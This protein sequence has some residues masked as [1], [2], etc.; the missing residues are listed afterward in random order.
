MSNY[1]LI[2]RDDADAFIAHS[3]G[4]WKKHKYI[5]K[6][7]KRYI[8]SAAPEFARKA[9]EYE[10]Y[11]RRKS[12]EDKEANNQTKRAMEEL[13]DYTKTQRRNGTKTLANKEYLTKGKLGYYK[14]DVR[15]GKP[16]DDMHGYVYRD[17]KDRTTVDK[18]VNRIKRKQ[19]NKRRTLSNRVPRAEV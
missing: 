7:G 18:V 6:D 3:S 17:N 11:R 4:P 1:I 9:E 10:E 19:K 12:M 14:D 5:S 13:N 15:P 8:Y 16:L 2:S